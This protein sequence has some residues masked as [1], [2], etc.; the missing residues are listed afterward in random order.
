MDENSQVTFSSW[1]TD[2]AKQDCC[3]WKGVACDNRTGHV[4][5]LVFGQEFQLKVNQFQPLR[6]KI[7]SQLTELQHLEYLDL[8]WNDFNRSQIPEFIG[9]LS[10]LSR[11]TSLTYLDLSYNRLSGRIP[12]NIG[13]MSKLERINV[14]G[15]SLKG[16]VSK[17]H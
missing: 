8:S 7:S 13:Q 2:A 12:E 10:N 16:V 1:G 3:R 5:K 4:V 6:G 9:S 15:N 17:T 14:T 11:M